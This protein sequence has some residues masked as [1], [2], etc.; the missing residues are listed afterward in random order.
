MQTNIAEDFDKYEW[1]F[2]Q[3]CDKNDILEM[4]IVDIIKDLTNSVCINLNDDIFTKVDPFERSSPFVAP[5]KPKEAIQEIAS[6]SKKIDQSKKMLLEL[7]RLNANVV[8]SDSSR[9]NDVSL[10]INKAF[11]FIKIINFLFV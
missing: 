2:E 11:C 7:R 9:V 3:N 6:T 5:I 8:K 10:L 1:T 4:E